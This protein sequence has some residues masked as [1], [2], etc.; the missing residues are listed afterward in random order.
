MD[1]IMKKALQILALYDGLKKSEGVMFSEFTKRYGISLST[2][3]R[4]LL[5]INAYLVAASPDEKVKYFKS[6]KIY[7]IV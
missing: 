2:F 4:Y 1:E 7:R 6:E 5:D 3:R